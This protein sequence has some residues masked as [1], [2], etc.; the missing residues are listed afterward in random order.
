MQERINLWSKLYKLSLH[1]FCSVLFEDD[2]KQFVKMF[3]CA[4]AQKVEPHEA[5]S[6]GRLE[7][8]TSRTTK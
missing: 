3:N 4:V 7:S 5:D 2:A 8:F 6:G 1:N